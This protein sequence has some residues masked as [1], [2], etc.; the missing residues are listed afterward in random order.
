MLTVVVHVSHD[1]RGM[2]FFECVRV[3]FRVD[4]SCLFCP[5]F[6][7]LFTVC[8]VVLLRF[9]VLFYVG[10]CIVCT[11]QSLWYYIMRQFWFSNIIFDCWIALQGIILCFLLSL[12]MQ[13]C[14][15][16]SVELYVQ[17]KKLFWNRSI[18]YTNSSKLTP[19]WRRF[20]SSSISP[21]SRFLEHLLH[22]F[23]VSYCDTPYVYTQPHFP[24]VCCVENQSR[25]FFAF[26]PFQSKQA[27]VNI[28]AYIEFFL[29][30]P[31][32]NVF[33]EDISFFRRFC[34][35]SQSNHKITFVIFSET[36]LSQ[37]A[38]PVLCTP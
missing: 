20:C 15:C 28:Y 36:W 11:N 16:M 26:P 32:T 27:Q 12:S 29:H 13:R 17:L 2:A 37:T 18:I 34:K 5:V 14:L 22:Y 23:R 6:L 4:I 24:W 33:H 31:S 35:A 25:H 3:F 9:W 1:G 8:F 19:L 30:Q 7:L 21:K 38:T 10:F